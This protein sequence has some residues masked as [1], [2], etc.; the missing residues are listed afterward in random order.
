M[1]KLIKN[2]D[3]NF[4][5]TGTSSILLN[6]PCDYIDCHL[7]ECKEGCPLYEVAE[8][9]WTEE[10]T[11]IFLEDFIADQNREDKK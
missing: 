8:E 4:E 9:E 6:Q 1:K 10:A 7:I 5:L 11:M 3:G 2:E